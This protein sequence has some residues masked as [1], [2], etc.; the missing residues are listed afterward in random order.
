MKI[1]KADIEWLD[2]TCYD[3]SEDIIKLIKSYIKETK[4]ESKKEL[5]NY[6]KAYNILMDCFDY[7]PEE[8]R[9]EISD[10]LEKLGL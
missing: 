10:D 4:K 6:K 9:Q 7:I 5:N 3:C 8:E 2:K 1:K